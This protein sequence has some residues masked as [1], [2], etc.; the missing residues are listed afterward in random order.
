MVQVADLF[1]LGLQFVVV[2]QPLFDLRLH[3]RPDAV[4]LGG[5]SGIADRQYPNRVASAG[6]A[7]RTPG[8]MTDDALEKRTAQD[9][10]GGREAVD[11]FLAAAE[12]LAM[13]HPII[14]KHSGEE[15]VKLPSRAF[16]KD[17]LV[18]NDYGIVGGRDTEDDDSYR[19][20]IHLKLTSQSGSNENA[21]RF[22]LLQVPGIQDVVFDSKAGTFHCHRLGGVETL[23]FPDRRRCVSHGK[24]QESAVLRWSCGARRQS[25]SCAQLNIS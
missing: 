2:L 1:Q 7:L 13:F 16:P 5:P 22:A 17:F 24:Y 8:L 18:T 3:L 12:S 20:R 14:L 6:G 19:Y 11:Q 21:L 25:R 10:V 23:A 4:L 9:L 15:P